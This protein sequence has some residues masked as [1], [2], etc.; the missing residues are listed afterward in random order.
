MR[1][2]T[3]TPDGK[4]IAVV[5]DDPPVGPRKDGPRHVG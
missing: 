4:Q 5:W 2:L 3:F 1:T